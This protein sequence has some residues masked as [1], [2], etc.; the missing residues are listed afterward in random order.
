[1]VHYLSEKMTLAFYNQQ[2]VYRSYNRGKRGRE[3]ILTWSSYMTIT[4]FHSLFC[5]KSSKSLTEGDL[6]QFTRY[7]LCKHSTRRNELRGSPLFYIFFGIHKDSQLSAF[8]DGKKQHQDFQ[9][10]L[11]DIV[12]VGLV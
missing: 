3:L 7:Y 8:L 10:L 6:P 12:I 1:M 9:G 2:N 5:N 11:L 4:P